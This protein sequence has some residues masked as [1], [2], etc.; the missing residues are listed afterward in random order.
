VATTKART[1]EYEVTLADDWAASSD[2]GGDP[3]LDDDEHWAPE[4]LL[5]TAL[6]RCTLTS[7]RYHARRAGLVAQTRGRAHGV[8]TTR[9][10][11]GRFAFVAIEVDLDVRFDGSPTPDSL[12]ELVAKAERDC[13]VG[14]SLRVPP[15]YRWTI[16]GRS[17]A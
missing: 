1:F 16:D 6:C 8:V 4:H 10:E 3:L 12:D 5:L 15:D 2:R 14:A 11:D 17:F 13:F 7:F 9:E